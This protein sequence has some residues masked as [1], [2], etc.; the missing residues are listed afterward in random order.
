MEARNIAEDIVC[1]LMA[2]NEIGSNRSRRGADGGR[3]KMDI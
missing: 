3:L 2:M 1:D